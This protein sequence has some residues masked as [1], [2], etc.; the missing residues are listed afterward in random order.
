MLSRKNNYM[1][2]NKEEG[3]KKL[4]EDLQDKNNAN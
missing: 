3:E 2:L 4:N 1:D